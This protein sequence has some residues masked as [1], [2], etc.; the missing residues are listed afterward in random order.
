[1]GNGS[2]SNI[3]VSLL[4]YSHPMF[5]RLD[6]PNAYIGKWG[7]LPVHFLKS[8]QETSLSG[9]HLR[10]EIIRWNGKIKIYVS[11]GDDGYTE[12]Y[13]SSM[14]EALI[15]LQEL[16]KLEPFSLWDLRLFGYEC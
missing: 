11:D 5:Y 13:F 14:D 7:E 10:A 2:Q 3:R 16:S 1:M 9:N 8:T 4:M 15:A 12:K 6:F